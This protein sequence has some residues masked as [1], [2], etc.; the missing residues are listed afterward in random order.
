MTGGTTR[1][2]RAG[3]PRRPGEEVLRKVDSSGSI[4]F[5]G[6]GYRVGNRYVGQV[7]G[8]RV[9]ADT[10]QITQH[11]LLLRTHLARH[12]KLKEFGAL[13]NP[14]GRPRRSAQD[15]A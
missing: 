14:G 4:S 12:H 3:D 11:A 6:T 1:R 8:V 13:A 2:L 7:V 10:I 9:V 15:V 5:A